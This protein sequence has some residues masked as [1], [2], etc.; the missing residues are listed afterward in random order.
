VID[1][2]NPAA[3]TADG[4]DDAIIGIGS[5][6][7]QPDL[8]VYDVETVIEILMQ[9]MSE[10]EAREFFDFNI[11]GSWVGEGTPIWLHRRTE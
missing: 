1:I 8:I 7:G 4:Y 5:R 2:D 10:E 6:C 9:D 3:L 11:G